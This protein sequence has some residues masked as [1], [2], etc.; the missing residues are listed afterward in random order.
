LVLQVVE[1]FTRTTLI[2]INLSGVVSLVQFLIVV[3]RVNVEI[4]VVIFETPALIY[5]FLKKNTLEKQL[6]SYIHFENKNITISQKTTVMLLGA[7]RDRPTNEGWDV[8]LGVLL[9]IVGGNSDVRTKRRTES[10]L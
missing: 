6:H 4:N 9:D 7:T 1:E 2:D 10:F 8:N 5:F 3:H